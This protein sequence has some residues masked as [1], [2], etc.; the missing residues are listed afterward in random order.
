[1][2]MGSLVITFYSSSGRLVG[3][4]KPAAHLGLERKLLELAHE[5]EV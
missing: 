5:A 2:D 3:V 1:M 4:D